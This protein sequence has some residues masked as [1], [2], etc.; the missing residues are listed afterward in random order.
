[1]AFRIN[2]AVIRGEIS[3]QMPGVVT[4]RIWLVGRQAPLELHLEGNCHL[5]LAGCSLTF[6]NPAPTFQEIGGL[7]TDQT[8][9]AGD[10]TASR[11][12]RIPTVPDEVLHELIGSGQPVPHRWANCLFLE[13]FSDSN[14]RVVI[15]AEGF[16][17]STSD[18]LWSLPDLPPATAPHTPERD[19]DPATDP[20]FDLLDDLSGTGADHPEDDPSEG[21]DDDDDDRNPFASDDPF[22]PE[23]LDEFEWE[24]EL[25][26][27]DAR[28]DRY[29]EALKKY[30]DHVDRERMLDQVMG[31]EAEIEDGAR[32]GFPDPP[33]AGGEDEDDDDFDPED[34]DYCG[35]HY[36]TERAMD[37]A[38]LIQKSAEMNHL[39]QEDGTAAQG[40]ES[41]ASRIVN[42]TIQ[43]GGKLAAG[44]DGMASGAE[45]DPGYVIAMLKRALIPL[46][47]A[48]QACADALVTHRHDPPNYVW[49]T[50]SRDELFDLRT[51]VLDLMAELRDHQ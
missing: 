18:P 31:W 45:P 40:D 29:Q 47:E 25:R 34:D 50:D 4:G 27:A 1:M 8:G 10:M 35:H 28:V 24:Q 12:A 16:S 7:A 5:D 14:G 48:L 44:L 26:D 49:I 30:E 36:L 17:L 3:N 32:D 51:E 38:L 6:A 23:P 42:S 37:L 41:P 46:N 33:E 21:E 19:A 11:K 9:L 20:A 15:E 22:D 13:W 39:L 43:L 2:H